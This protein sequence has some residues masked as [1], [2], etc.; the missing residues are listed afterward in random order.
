M[1]FEN[2]LQIIDNE[3]LFETGLLLSGNIDSFNVRKQ[4]S[5]WTAS[6]KIYQL[7][8]GLY[9]LA[10]PYQKS[11][12][13]PFFSANRLV[14]G[15]YVSLQSAL[16]YF[17]MIP[18]FVPTTTSVTTAH[19]I[20]YRTPIGQYDFRHIQVRWFHSYHRKDLGNNQWAFIAT[21][22]KALLD[23][24]YLQPGGDEEDYLH[25]LRLQAMDQLDMGLLQRLATTAN[26]PKLVR[27]VKIIQHMVD[28]EKTGY[29]S[30]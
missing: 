21:P 24:V 23:L 18:E 20:T 11:V 1:N 2:L 14:A 17:G 19:P 27:A 28:E 8:R 5:R 22:E 12:P 6:G 16:A 25:S 3:P 26:R 13:H 7:R 15:S 30:L 10:Q 9:S 29:Q 4:L